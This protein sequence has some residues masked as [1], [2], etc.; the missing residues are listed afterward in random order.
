MPPYLTYAPFVPINQEISETSNKDTIKEKDKSSDSS[1]LS[2][3]DLMLML[4][5]MDGLPN[6]ISIIISNLRNMNQL[7]QILPSSNTASKLVDLYLNSLYKSKVANFNKKIFDE[8]YKKAQNNDALPEFAITEG[9]QLVAQNKETKQLNYVSVDDYLQ[10]PDKFGSKGKY[11]ILTNSNLLNFRAYSP[12]FSFNNGVFSIVENGIGLQKVQ[13]LVKSSLQNLGNTKYESPFSVYQQNGKVL[14]GAEI[15]KQLQDKGLMGSTLEDGV[16]EGK[17]ITENQKEQAMAALNYI[18]RTLPTNA[19]TLLKLRSGNAKDPTNGA[20]QLLY[21]LITSTTSDNVSLSLEY[22][23]QRSNDLKKKTNNSSNSEDGLDDIE[24]NAAAQFTMGMGYASVYTMYDGTSDGLNLYSTEMPV[25]KNNNNIGRSTLLDLT[26]SDF[27]GILDFSNASMGGLTLTSAGFK[28]VMTDGIAHQVDMIID[29]KALSRGKIIPDFRLFKKKE[30][31][32]AYIKQQGIDKRDFNKI[33]E[34]Y[35]QFNLPLLYNDKGELNT[36]MYA[37]FAVFNSTALSTAFTEDQ[38]TDVTFNDFLKELTDIDE[39]NALAEFKSI[40]D[41]LKYDGKSAW[42]SVM[43]FLNDHDS[44][45]EGTVFIPIKSHVLNAL[46]KE[47][48]GR[49]IQVLEAAE[50]AKNREQSLREKFNN[51]NKYKE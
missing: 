16:Y 45:Y 23:S 8:T 1:K 35:R 14:Q 2:D 15:L 42:D 4:K 25:T 44:V 19:Q 38:I 49:Q 9:G 24:Y 26:S 34:I 18:Y 21:S 36:Q 13:E 39:E 47:M 31:A 20:I 51:G 43:P 6:D 22:N 30:Q 11:T 10:N 3:K 37:K 12:E 32:D 48:T 29:Q 7:Q 50:Q 41:K 40:D 27:G 5:E 46:S 33:N 17:Y 28:K